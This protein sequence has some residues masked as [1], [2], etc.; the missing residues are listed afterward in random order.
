[1]AP[2]HQDRHHLS[3]E[4]IQLELYPKGLT[5]HLSAALIHPVRPLVLISLSPHL[6]P[7]RPT[8]PTRL[9][10]LVEPNQLE[11][12]HLQLHLLVEP[13]LQDTYQG[14]HHHPNHRLLFWSL[15]NPIHPERHPTLAELSLQ[16]LFEYSTLPSLVE[17]I[18]PL[19]L[20]DQDRHHQLLC[21]GRPTQLMRPHIQ[22]EPTQ[23]VSLCLHT[24][25]LL[26]EHIR[27][28]THHLHI[29]DHQ[30]SDQVAHI[31]PIRHLIHMAPIQLALSQWEHPS[32]E[33]PIHQDSPLNHNLPHKAHSFQNRPIQPMLH[34]ILSPNC[35]TCD[36]ISWWTKSN[37]L[38]K[39]NLS[40][41]HCTPTSTISKWYL[42]TRIHG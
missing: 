33:E 42:S 24:H 36:T 20:S 14:K 25:L 30:H 23:P 27:Q 6:G 3:A 41:R 9:H 32:L 8:Q 11:L 26:A 40:I 39:W 35:H 19:S 28:A 13:I 38:S 2:I 5:L 34:H 31:Q 4:P 10:T 22:V 17:H 21:Q 12:Y 15:E 1:M 7:T 37:T 18:H 16:A 29:T